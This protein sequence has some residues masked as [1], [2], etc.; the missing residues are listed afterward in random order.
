MAGT[1]QLDVQEFRDLTRWRWVLADSGGAFVADHEVRLDPAA[2][3]YEAFTDLTGYLSWH[4]APDRRSEDEAR[5]VGEL[6]AWI[7][8]R[9]LGP[10][11][12]ALAARRPTTVRVTV[13]TEAAELLYRPLELA[14]AGGQP[15][16]VQD[17]T[18]VLEAGRDAVQEPVPV[19]E[20]LR[21]LGLFSLPEGGRSLNLRRERAELVRLM[22][23]IAATGK[24]VDVRVLQYGAT[25]GRL[26]DVLE[27]AEGWDIIHV[28]GH[29]RP[30]WLTL[31]TATGQPDRVSAIELADLLNPA[32]A[33]LKLIT[34]SACWSAAVLADEQRSQLGLPLQDQDRDGT[35]ERSLADGTPAASSGVLATELVD[36]LGCAVLAMRY[37]VGDDFAITL[38]R[39]LYA[40]LAEEGQ[41]LPRALGMTLRELSTGKSQAGPPGGGGGSGVDGSTFPAL[42]VA[43]PALFGGVAADLRL[44][45]PSLS[46]PITYDTTLMKMAGFP[47]PPERF[48]GRTAVLA[49][50]SSALA[51]R[52]GV[53]G[54]LLHGMPGGGKTACALELAHGHEDAFD[55]FVWYKAPDE[56]MATDGALTEFALTLERH[57]PGFQMVDALASAERLAAFLPRLTELLEQRRLLIVIDNL[58]SLLTEIGSCRD[59][60]WD[61][62]IGALAAHTGIGRVI[63]TSRRL[64]ARGV[65]GIQVE[66]VDALSADEALL[67]ARELPNLAALKL[68]QVPGL[69][70]TVSKRFARNAMAMARGHPKLLEL[71]EGQAANPAHLLELVKTGDQEWRRLGGVPDGFFADGEATASGEDYLTVLAAWTKTVT[72][73]LMPGERDLFWLLCC[74]EEHDRELDFLEATWDGLWERLGHD[75]PLPAI[76]QALV[77]I[78]VSGLATRQPATH[79]ADESYLVHPAIAAAGRE[80][81]GQR[82]QDSADAVA[83]LYCYAVYEVASGAGSDGQVH[84]ELTLD[85]GLAAV[86]Y[87]IRQQL[88]SV[89]AAILERVFLYDPSA[90]NAAVALPAIRQITRH[91]PSNAA[92]L[93]R[94][95]EA[96]D[97][98]AADAQA[99]AHLDS[100]VTAGDFRTACSVASF[101]TDLCRESGRLDEALTFAEQTADCARQAG[102]GPWTQLA[103]E[104]R[105]LQVL[106]ELGQARQVLDEVGSL[107]D[108]MQGL[109]LT[110]GPDEAT[111]PWNVREALLNT[112]QSAAVA[113]G[114]WDA[115][116]SLSAEIT[117]SMRERRAP[118][119][120]IARARFNDYGPLLG[121]GRVEEALTLLRDCRR[122]LQDAQDIASLGAVFTALADVEDARGHGIA[123]CRL[124]RDALRYKYLAEDVTSIAISYHNLGGYLHDHA[125]DPATALASRLAAALIRVLVGISGTG[126]NTPAN[127]VRGAVADLRVL[128][129]GT[130]P[131]ASVADLARQVGEIPGTDLP[132]LIAK[133][134]PDPGTADRLLRDLI[135]Q[136]QEQAASP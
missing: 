25:R 73:T 130:A 87:L 126:S 53:P 69:G 83:A 84:T 98:A 132:G 26:R 41:P 31:E 122:V 121:L 37:P 42:S 49:R 105:R 54:V 71:A 39:K 111:P 124:E 2:W 27:E 70:A 102:H 20:R 43:T 133:L 9:V 89:A 62:V 21:V 72:D 107:R 7:G 18:L 120:D 113:L 108:R 16:A 34:V 4:A 11:A 24:A 40:L 55:R 35:S 50:S 119:T 44:A 23:G 46:A 85:A 109:P 51:I 114:E 79:E 3:E 65:A 128:G 103:A 90:A 8:S 104:G 61:S 64:P 15:L 77:T 74:L 30:G 22:R 123:A 118:A 63:L 29:G 100:A 94:I 76:Q 36:R 86:P 112:G 38:S 136:A 66:T 135:A 116:L 131:P 58:E 33:R 115:A 19:G 129:P 32:R 92:I 12:G 106:D 56:G 28:S 81:A 59:E 75:G 48:V 52:S 6:G 17:V 68:G 88:W 101:L 97:P 57:L 5:I 47:P 99:R 127:A 134:S 95:L 80:H 93:A 78:T 45:A 91:D 1:L 117:T 96:I 13:P 67:L 82:F 125:R 110:R 10:V 14:H 60:R